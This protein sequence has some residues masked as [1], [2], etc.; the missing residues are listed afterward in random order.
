MIANKLAFVL[1]L[2]LFGY[3]SAQ[4]SSS[5]ATSASGSSI[6]TSPA[7]I[8]PCIIECVTTA[9]TQN[10]CSS[11]TDIAC[12]CSN[13]QFQQA[14]L[15]CLQA[16]CTAADVAAATQLQQSQCSSASG[17]PTVTDSSTATGSGSGT[18]VPPNSS[19]TSPASDSGSGAS[20][21]GASNTGSGTTSG[22]GAAETTS[23]TGSA[24]PL[25]SL[26]GPGVVWAGITGLVGVVLGGALVI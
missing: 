21:S 4:D 9:A 2:A 8:S 20:N 5:A 19:A 15:A 7:G 18:Q 17:S 24:V 13:T 6:P 1:S 14:S 16:N 26:S 25:R 23:D 12:V 10:G 22:T 3:V 11:F